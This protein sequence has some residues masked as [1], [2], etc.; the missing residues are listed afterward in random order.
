MPSISDVGVCFPWCSWEQ[1]EKKQGAPL[2]LREDAGETRAKRVRFG[3]GV[4]KN[5][6]ADDLVECGNRQREKKKKDGSL[7][8]MCMK[9]GKHNGLGRC[10]KREKEKQRA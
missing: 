4:R 5:A 6:A 10:G 7:G 3:R 1:V 2:Q 8:F 9:N